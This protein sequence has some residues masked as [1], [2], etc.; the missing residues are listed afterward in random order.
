MEKTLCCWFCTSGPVSITARTD[1]RGYCPG[2]H[3]TMNQLLVLIESLC[4]E[5]GT[6]SY[7]FYTRS[8]V[9]VFPSLQRRHINIFYC[10]FCIHIYTSTIS[11]CICSLIMVHCLCRGVHSDFCRVQQPLLSYRDA[12]RHP[13]PI[14]DLFCWEQIKASENK[15]LHDIR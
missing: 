6:F 14:P 4:M 1:R 3:A 12:S 13:L 8:M 15:V 2:S 11:H 10:T 7:I 5:Y 9:L